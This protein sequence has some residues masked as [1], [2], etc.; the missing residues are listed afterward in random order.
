MDKK[1]VNQ[2]NVLLIIAVIYTLISILAITSYLSSI[3]R[4]STTTYSIGGLLSAM[5]W[6]LLMII[7][8]SVAY[9]LYLKKGKLGAF[10][11][12]IIGLA[13]FINVIVSIVLQGANLLAIVLELIFPFALMLH[14][15]YVIKGIKKDKATKKKPAIK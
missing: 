1:N 2:K 5:W 8:L 12:I 15:F 11:E 13:M 7:L 9:I 10:L 6:Q 3:A 4:V 14:G